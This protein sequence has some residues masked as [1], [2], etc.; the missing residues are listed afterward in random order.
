MTKRDRVVCCLIVAFLVGCGTAVPASSRVIPIGNSEPAENTTWAVIRPS[1]STIERKPAPTGTASPAWT[2]T[3]YPDIHPHGP[4]LFTGSML[5]NPDGSGQRILPYM[6][7]R[8]AYGVSPNGEW[9]LEYSGSDILYGEDEVMSLGLIHV[10][11]GERISLATII[12]KS[13]LEEN[14]PAIHGECGSYYLGMLQEYVWSPD[15]R[16]LAFAA[17][18]SGKA[19]DLFSYDTKQRVLR[20]LTNQTAEILQIAWSLDSRTIYY[21]NA[22][23][24][25]FD[26]TF[27]AFTL[28]ATRPENSPNQGIRTLVTISDRPFIRWIGEADLLVSVRKEEWCMAGGYPPSVQLL[29]IMV[30]EQVSKNILPWPYGYVVAIDPTYR[31]LILESLGKLSGTADGYY[32]VSFDGEIRSRVNLPFDECR[33]VYPLGE[34]ENEFLCESKDGRIAGISATGEWHMV[35]SEKID[36]SQISVSPDR[37]WFIQY[38]REEA[39]VYSRSGELI[40]TWTVRQPDSRATYSDAGILWTPDGKGV[41]IAMGT[42]DISY[43]PFADPTPRTIFTCSNSTDCVGKIFWVDWE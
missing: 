23:E 42:R 5:I 15:G 20:R 14:Y 36:N 32:L 27:E 7:S 16:Y 39:R 17:N 8:P 1:T 19:L 10:P 13:M 21:T 11:D 4:Y 30:K 37:Q 25:T 9:S 29:H 33:R 6:E 34:Q 22:H 24:M 35:E 38:N 3:P 2:A 31:M 18:T 26:V 41:Y 43:I 28:N 40:Y 12:T